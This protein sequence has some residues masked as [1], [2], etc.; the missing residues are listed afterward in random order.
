MFGSNMVLQH[1]RPAPIWGW[2]PVGTDIDVLFD[3]SSVKATAAA[4][5]GLWK[6]SLPA[7]KATT[8]GRSIVVSAPLPGFANIT[9]VNVV[10]G[11]VVFCSGQSNSEFNATIEAGHAVRSLLTHY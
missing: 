3:G 11:E 7:Q 5:A 8:A 1:D 9:I 6:A 10:F 4:P 2:A